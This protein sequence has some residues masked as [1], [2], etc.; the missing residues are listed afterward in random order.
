MLPPFLSGEKVGVLSAGNASAASHAPT[1][2]TTTHSAPR[3]TASAQATTAAAAPSASASA[4]V[5]AAA[6]NQE[7]A[8]LAYLNTPKGPVGLNAAQ[9]GHWV[10]THYTTFSFLDF[11]Q[12][13]IPYREQHCMAELVAKLKEGMDAISCEYIDHQEKLYNLLPLLPHLLISKDQLFTP[14]DYKL[15]QHCAQMLAAG[16]PPFLA[17]LPPEWRTAYTNRY[18]LYD[19]EPQQLERVNGKV[20]MD[21]GGYIGDTVLVFRDLFPQA[22]IYTYE[23][24]KANY[25]RICH[26]FAQD[27]AN[28]RVHAFQQGVGEKAGSMQ[29]N[30]SRA[31][32]STATLLKAPMPANVQQEIEIVTIDEVVAQNK[33][34]VGLIKADV[35]GFEPEVVRGALET[36]K[37]QKPL[38][39]LAIY[40][41]A[42][43]YYELKPYLESLNLGYTFKLRRSCFSNPLGELVLIGTP[44]L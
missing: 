44:Q 27:I 20:I 31:G 28:G 34:Q 9:F 36:I 18:G 42:T 40:H 22:Q 5:S 23:P 12:F 8:P 30:F 10:H 11:E 35:E 41:R 26:T 4:T 15:Q 13:F 38:L 3:A 25:D 39:V 16:T 1:N 21:V 19:T 24:V 17:Q 7:Q 6:P 29:L 32:D 37:S 33:L 14:L 43:E 2:T